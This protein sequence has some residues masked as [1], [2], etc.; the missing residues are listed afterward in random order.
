M[1]LPILSSESDRRMEASYQSLGSQSL[2][3][4][5]SFQDRDGGFSLGGRS[6]DLTNAYFQIP[7]HLVS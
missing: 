1:H 6:V 5:Y 4:P 3:D 2:C 7:I